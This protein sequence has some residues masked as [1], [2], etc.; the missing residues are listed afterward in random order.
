MLITF[1]LDEVL[2]LNPFGSGVFPYVRQVI[3]ERSGADT[4]AVRR[5]ILDEAIARQ[6]RGDMLAAYDWDDIIRRVSAGFN[7][8]WTVSIAELVEKYCVAPHIRLH[9]GAQEVLA[10]LKAQGHTLRALTNG[11]YKY[12]FPV[13]KALGIAHFFERIVTPD[14][15]GAAKPQP[16]FFEAARAGGAADRPGGDASGVAH[17]HI[18]DHAIHDVWGANRIGAVSIWVHHNL[19]EDWANKTPSQRAGEPAIPELVEQAIA[20]DLCPECYPDLKPED[21]RPRFVI[22]RLAEIPGIIAQL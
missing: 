17:V 6:R 16:E 7:V 9:E 11:Y 3:S 18:G 21:A 4:A 19:P 13:L 14:Q 5:A 15:V 10:E 20:K 2:I 1:D 22:S 12:Q 8:E